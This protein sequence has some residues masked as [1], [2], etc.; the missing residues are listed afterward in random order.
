MDAQGKPTDVLSQWMEIQKNFYDQWLGASGSIFHPWADAMKA[1]SGGRPTSAGLDLF[2]RWSEM[3]RDTIQKA[4]GG[5]A[6]GIGPEV[7][8]RI[9][10]S[11]NVFVLFNQFWLEILKDLPKLYQAK[12]DEAASRQIY[13]RWVELYKTVFEQII[14]SPVSKTAEEIMASWV[15]T[16]QMRQSAFGM[17]W[18]PWIQSMPQWQEQMARFLRGDWSALQEGRSLWREVYDETLGKVFRMPAFGLTKQ[19]TEQLRRT[20][21]AYLQFWNAVPGFYQFFYKTGM[22]A[23]HEFFERLKHFKADEMTPERL[24]E[25]YRIW[26]TT[27][28]NALFELFKKPEFCS[29]MG[30]VLNYGLRL[31][32]RMD[33]LTDE[34]CRACSLPSRKDYDELA[35]AV[36]ELRRKARRQQKLIETLQKKPGSPV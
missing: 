6:G 11:S 1:W 12:W 10:R 24:K 15:N 3:I 30:E 13:D 4:A 34:W 19:H 36:H 7:M 33:E 9:L 27:N 8:F 16:L 25:V 14:G 20:W 5:A 18:G 35:E 2:A 31:K 17:M 29:A 26:W 23:L 32:K 28:E 21:D 22:D